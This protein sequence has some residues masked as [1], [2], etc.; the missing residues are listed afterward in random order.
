MPKHLC[1]VHVDESGKLFF[2]D[3]NYHRQITTPAEFSR[4]RKRMYDENSPPIMVDIV[5]VELINQEYRKQSVLPGT[6]HLM[7]KMYESSIHYLQLKQYD[8]AANQFELLQS[9][10][11]VVTPETEELFLK[12]WHSCPSASRSDFLMRVVET[13]CFKSEFHWI[14]LILSQDNLKDWLQKNQCWLQAICYQ[15]KIDLLITALSALPSG[16]TIDES[17]PEIREALTAVSASAQ[18]QQLT[19]LIRLLI[20]KNLLAQGTDCS[21]SFVSLLVFYPQDMMILRTA[22]RVWQQYCQENRLRKTLRNSASRSLL[23]H[24]IFEQ[25][26]LSIMQLLVSDTSYIL[27]KEDCFFMLCSPYQELKTFLQLQPEKLAPEFEQGSLFYLSAYGDPDNKIRAIL[28]S[29]QQNITFNTLSECFCLAALNDHHDLCSLM[30]SHNPKCLSL[31]FIETVMI[32]ALKMQRNNAISFLLTLNPQHTPA[33][34][35]EIFIKAIYHAKK[36]IALLLNQD[37][38]FAPAIFKNPLLRNHIKNKKGSLNKII[39]IFL[40]LGMQQ[41]DLNDTTLWPSAPL[42]HAVMKSDQ[43]LVLQLLSQGASFNAPFDEHLPLNIAIRL[44]DLSMIVL[45]IENGAD[46]N[47]LDKS[48]RAPAY[49][50]VLY[51]QPNA[52]ALLN[53]KGADLSL[54]LTSNDTPLIRA[55]YDKKSFFFMKLLSY[56]AEPLNIRE[57]LNV[58]QQQLKPLGCEQRW[59]NIFLQIVLDNNNQKVLQALKDHGVTINTQIIDYRQAVFKAV[60]ENQLEWLRLFLSMTPSHMTLDLIEHSLN[61][62]PLIAAINNNHLEIAQVLLEAGASPHFSLISQYPPLYHAV[63]HHKVAMVSL[64]LSYGAHYH[65][66]PEILFLAMKQ[67]SPAILEKLLTI[68]PDN[69][70][71]LNEAIA[72]AQQHNC[73]T[74]LS[75]LSAI[76]IRADQKSERPALVTPRMSKKRRYD[77]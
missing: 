45:L 72:V 58:L 39:E 73:Q 22:I 14:K 57:F 74:A 60:S 34:E 61:A 55:I 18:Q 28:Q 35:Q 23:E 69:Q 15:V 25:Y 56:G 54:G 53:D 47:A 40:A 37:K 32:M 66:A 38:N 52:L 49:Y 50:A 9:L 16:Y 4:Y 33:L 6:Q 19:H 27:S 29:Q 11:H 46:I 64:L 31:D 36:E 8:I 13:T 71:L 70:D 43:A 30:A 51:D 63:S 77:L 21:K 62:T 12:A 20:L 67:E 75:L 1:A 48:G 59:F 5:A 44:G 7:R 26:P 17:L 68:F 10:C 76:S 41:N 3:P 42:N 2:Y 24:M 65:S